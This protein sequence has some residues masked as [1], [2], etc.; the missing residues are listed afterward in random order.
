MTVVAGAALG[1]TT[2]PATILLHR[3]RELDSPF[4]L[5][6]LDLAVERTSIR[7]PDP[8]SLRDDSEV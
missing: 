7:Y 3:E 5:C 2:R 6:R 1:S 8:K 4:D